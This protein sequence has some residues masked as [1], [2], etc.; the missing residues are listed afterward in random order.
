MAGW[1]E[2][3]GL[4]FLIAASSCVV[5]GQELTVIQPPDKSLQV[6]VFSDEQ[7][8]QKFVIPLTRSENRWVPV[9][10]DT[11]KEQRAALLKL[12]PEQE[13]SQALQRAAEEPKLVDRTIEVSGSSSEGLRLQIS[14]GGQARPKE[15]VVVPSTGP[16]ARTWSLSPQSEGLD[17][18]TGGSTSKETAVLKSLV[19][20]MGKSPGQRATKAALINLLGESGASEP[21]KPFLLVDG[22]LYWVTRMDVPGSSPGGGP[23]IEEGGSREGPQGGAW[24]IGAI[25][26]AIGFFAAGFFSRPLVSRF[27]KRSEEGEGAENMSVTFASRSEPEAEVVVGSGPAGLAQLGMSEGPKGG[28]DSDQEIVALTRQVQSL[29]DANQELEKQVAEAARAPGP[30]SRDKKLEK[31]R[32]EIDSLKVQLGN[33]QALAAQQDADLKSQQATY[34]EQGRLLDEVNKRNL[35]LVSQY[36]QAEKAKEAFKA[37]AMSFE[38]EA[39]N[40]RE[41]VRISRD[42]AAFARQ[43]ASRLQVY[44]EEADH[45][46]ADL[47]QAILPPA[48]QQNSADTS[49]GRPLPGIFFEGQGSPK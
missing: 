42:D 6:L 23:P 48:E 9:E 46:L 40:L 8:R 38:K 32:R 1:I 13:L 3:A 19:F 12:L 37:Q 27:R 49:G 33:A 26:G 5:L 25:L 44:A 39:A 15:L 10:S 36:N 45:A 30:E 28:Q 14:S 34:R 17:V 29:Q 16:D 47:I 31:L 24:V 20:L 2:R 41:E 11:Y 21:K 22:S 43:E 4:A 7:T 18:L 35:D